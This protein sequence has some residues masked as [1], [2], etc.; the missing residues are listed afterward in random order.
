MQHG[1]CLPTDG[2]FKL[3]KG[4]AEHFRAEGGEFRAMGF[5][6]YR[7]KV[8]AVYVREGPFGNPEP[9]TLKS[10]VQDFVGGVGGGGGVKRL[11]EKTG[12]T[13]GLGAW[14]FA[15]EGSWAF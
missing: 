13:L 9:Q 15:F 1:V 2:P 8:L 7:F 3:A 12:C 6:M 11:G 5:C 10:Q 4:L 14:D